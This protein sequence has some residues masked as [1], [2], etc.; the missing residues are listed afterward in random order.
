MTSGFSITGAA[1]SQAYTREEIIAMEA[2]ILNALDW[3]LC[4]ATPWNFHHRFCSAGRLDEKTRLTAE[5]LMERYLQEIKSLH[6]LPS[7]VTAGA[8]SLAL[9][10]NGLPTWV[11]IQ[12]SV[13]CASLAHYPLP[14]SLPIG[15][16]LE[17]LPRSVHCPKHP[18][19][20]HRTLAASRY[21]LWCRTPTW[22]STLATAK[23]PSEP[24][25]RSCST[26]PS[27]RRTRA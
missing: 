2:K 15:D 14:P 11:R 19:A 26:A 9:R 4:G 3:D 13:F 21:A 22:P 18:A 8:V 25:R 7:K 16:T 12:L 5:Y 24:S 17:A 10:L 1:R 20:D 27:A 6:H 23:I